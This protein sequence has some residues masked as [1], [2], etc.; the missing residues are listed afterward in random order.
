[1][2][3]VVGIGDETW[4]E[5]RDAASRLRRDTNLAWF[6][7][8][9]A[10]CRAIEAGSDAGDWPDLIVAAQARPGEFPWCDLDRLRLAAPTAPIVAILGSWC[11][12]ELRRGSTWPFAMRVPWDRWDL[13]SSVEFERLACD[14][15]WRF[16]YPATSDDEEHLWRDAATFREALPGVA[17]VACRD[18]EKAAMCASICGKRGLCVIRVAPSRLAR[19]QG[20][21]VVVWDPPGAMLDAASVQRAKAVFPGAELLAIAA[22]AGHDEIAAARRAGADAVLPW[23]LMVAQFERELERLL[24]GPANAPR[25]PAAAQE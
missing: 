6:M 11:A 7:H 16:G 25:R 4:F 15:S 12:G 18:A 14:G 10:A 17:A 2:L 23:P 8:P 24:Q 19:L 21:A 9:A 3:N 5:F 22:F 1:M 20:V 13:V